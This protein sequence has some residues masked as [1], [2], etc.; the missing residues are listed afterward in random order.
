MQ[1]KIK[2]S[3]VKNHLDTSSSAGGEKQLV[4]SDSTED[5]YMW[6]TNKM[7]ISGAEE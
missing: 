2:V 7:K 1:I 3:K 4:E 6:R 5:N